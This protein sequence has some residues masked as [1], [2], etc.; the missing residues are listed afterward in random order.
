MTSKYEKYIPLIKEVCK[1]KGFDIDLEHPTTIQDKLNWYNIYDY[2]SRKTNC[3]DKYLLHKHSETKLGKDFCIPMYKVYKNVLE[4]DWKSLPNKFVIRCNHGSGMHIVVRDKSKADISGIMAQLNKWMEED[5]TFRNNFEFCYHEIEHRIMVEELLEDPS[6]PKLLQTFRFW[7]FNGKVKFMSVQEGEFGPINHYDADENFM[8][9]LSRTDY[10]S[11]YK[12]DYFIP[13][14]YDAMKLY[15]RRLAEDFEFACVDFYEVNG[16]PYLK[17]MCF[18]PNANYFLYKEVESNFKVGKMLTLG[19]KGENEH[20]GTY[21]MFET[22]LPKPQV[23]PIAAEKS[24]EVKPKVEQKPVNSQ[25]QPK[26]NTQK[27]EALIEKKVKEIL[28]KK[29]K[30]DEAKKVVKPVGRQVYYGSNLLSG[31]I[32]SPSDNI[33]PKAYPKKTTFLGSNDE[34]SVS[35]SEKIIEQKGSMEK[36]ET[37]LKI[38]LSSIFKDDAQAI[39]YLKTEVLKD[40]SIFWEVNNAIEENR[41]MNLI[42]RES[43]EKVI[44]DYVWKST[45]SILSEDIATEDGRFIPQKFEQPKNIIASENVVYETNLTTYQNSFNLN[46]IK[47]EVPMEVE[48]EEVEE[49][50]EF[51][52]AEGNSETINLCI[53]H[54]NTP[55]LTECLIRSINKFTPNCVIY[56]FDNSDK[57]PFT[58]RQDNIIYLDNTKGQYIDFEKW[59]QKYPNRKRSPEATHQFG[60]AK[61]C[62]SVEKCMELIDKNFILLDS[63]ILLKKDI[64]VFND[65]KYIFVGTTEKQPFVGIS[66]V[67]PFVCFIN[68]DA[69]KFYDVHYFDENRMHGLFNNAIIA[70]ADHYDTG[71]AFLYHAKPYPHKEIDYRGYIEHFKGGSW[72][73]ISSR[74]GNRT[75]SSKDWLAKFKNLWDDTKPFRKVVYTC[76]TG[77]YES[78]KKPSY[79]N[80]DFDYICFT[81]ADIKS[82]FWQIRPLPKE[83]EGLSNVKKQRYVK[84]N[85]HKVLPEYDFSV[86]IDGNVDIRGNINEYIAANCQRSKGVISI[87]THPER[88]CTYEEAKACVHYKKDTMDNMAEQIDFYRKEGLPEHYG[89]VQ[90]CIVFRYHNDEQCVQLMEEWWNELYS[91]KSH[92]DQ[93]SISYVQWKTG[94][95]INKLDKSIFKN[96]Y[97]W[98]G[99]THR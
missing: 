49:E 15:A 92:R 55:K 5:Y 60:S 58:Y 57:E 64:S 4:I 43:V 52:I 77:G 10:P 18:T 53:I 16:K 30:E 48:V 54:Y 94:I 79:V 7:C 45:N 82:D 99:V 97:F 95:R 37:S 42:K 66:R 31:G 78:L 87:G 88:D 17:K 59:L 65:N 61:H 12:S 2:P 90:T 96:K 73:N 68:V 67:L 21:K 56:I 46:G 40:K 71:A 11:Q 28:Q 8:K 89:L 29:V 85:A 50:K 13:Y 23:K 84:I 32:S 47:K 41:R 80:A 24:V 69:C 63:D 93:L 62:V 14:N 6:Q 26:V 3:T 19:I 36:P 1:K 51:F 83:T 76:I 25:P 98:W 22:L 72:E 27:V 33:I 70:N 34:Y 38:S 20:Q 74:R 81:D 35:D 9:W 44:S 91:H 86:W 75:M 39:D